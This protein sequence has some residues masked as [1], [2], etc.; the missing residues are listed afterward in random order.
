MGIMDG[1]A[2]YQIIKSGFGLAFIV[3]LLCLAIGFTIN[4]M[5][6]NYLSTTVCNIKSIPKSN[7]SNYDQK[8]TYTVNGQN[9]E[10]IIPGVTTTTNN[11]TTTNYAHR[12]GNCTLYY[13]KAKPEEY[14]LNYNP[15]TV[16]S[17]FAV[18]LFII[19]IMSGIW[20][21]FLRSHREFAGVMGGISAADDIMD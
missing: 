6:K 5:N 9:Y 16:S 13:P 3:L 11:V 15:T 20:F 19:A 4:N 1:L 8:L 7:N 12:E 14:S 18:V 2:T 10:Y 17:I 21:L